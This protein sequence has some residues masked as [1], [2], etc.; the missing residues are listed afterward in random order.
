MLFLNL[1]LNAYWPV[2]EPRYNID[3]EYTVSFPVIG[4]TIST[5]MVWAGNVP[6]PHWSTKF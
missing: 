6:R 2:D 3:I 1:G 5:L 4:G